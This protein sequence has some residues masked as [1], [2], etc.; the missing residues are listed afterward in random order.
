MVR[1]VEELVDAARPADCSIG[2]GVLLPVNLPSGTVVAMYQ[3]D[4]SEHGRRVATQTGP[5]LCTSTLS[6]LWELPG[7]IPV[8]VGSISATVRDGLLEQP[9]LV[10]QPASGLVCREYEPCGAVTGLFAAAKSADAA[11]RQASLLSPIYS[12]WAVTGEVDGCEWQRVVDA[13]EHCGV[14][15]IA[16][17]N[18]GGAMSASPGA[19]VLGRP[20]VFRWWMVE[21]A[22]ASW[23]ARAEP[24]R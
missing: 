14:G 24:T 2:S 17:D 9:G 3:P 15:V 7:G 21:V 8:P 23:L 13:A 4:Q 11:L 12:R 5:I 1:C 19:P 20:H 6:A 16:H 18:N 22:Y 10:A